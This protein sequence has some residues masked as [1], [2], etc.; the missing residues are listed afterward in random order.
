MISLTLVERLHGLELKKG[1][2][3]IDIDSRHL[4]YFCIFDPMRLGS[5]ATE[6]FFFFFIMLGVVEIR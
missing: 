5:L 6:T 1:S 3:K 4:F 2:L